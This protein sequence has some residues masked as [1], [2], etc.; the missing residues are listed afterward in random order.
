MTGPFLFVGYL[1]EPE[2]TADAFDGEWLDTGDLAEKD[3]EGFIRIAG[4]SKDII[5]R[6]GENIPVAYIENVLYEHPAVSQVAVVAVPHPRLQEIACAVVTLNEG[7]S[8]SMDEL[9]EFFDTKGVA[10]NYWPEALQCLDEFPRTPS[11][12]IQKFKLREE[13]ATEH[14]S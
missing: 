11:G 6:G 5:I 3:E 7:H 2:Q 8:L 13:V 4:R 9:R 14:V 12:K 1:D 10:K